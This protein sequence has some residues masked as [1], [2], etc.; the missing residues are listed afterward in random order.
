MVENT[1]FNSRERVASESRAQ[2]QSLLN[3]HPPEA[4]HLDAVTSAMDISLGANGVFP[5][6]LMVKSN[7]GPLSGGPLKNE[8]LGSA[9]QTQLDRLWHERRGTRMATAEE[10]NGFDEGQSLR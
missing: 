9:A 8:A 4:W 10:Q 1:S 6:V 5:L 2:E 7:G 3:S